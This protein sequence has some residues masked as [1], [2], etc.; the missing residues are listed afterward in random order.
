MAKLVVVGGSGKVAK[1]FSSLASKHF[2]ITSLVRSRDHFD[3]IKQAGATP[4]ILDIENAGVDE[5][6]RA[7]EG[8]QGVLFAAGAGGKGGK[9]RTKKV[10]EEGAIKVSVDWRA[11]LRQVGVAV[12]GLTELESRALASQ[13]LDRKLT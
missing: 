8:A 1:L 3:A 9:E 6:K 2:T 13:G 4:E 7:F 12:G 5:L 11:E 10:D